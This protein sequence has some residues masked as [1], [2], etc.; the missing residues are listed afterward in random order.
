M[1]LG[2]MFLL[3]ARLA[4]FSEQRSRTRAYSCHFLRN[5]RIEMMRQMKLHM[6]ESAWALSAASHMHCHCAM[7]AA[8]TPSSP[9]EDMIQRCEETP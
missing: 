2:D 6:A 1:F 4:M 7:F 3:A 8:M 5:N 9:F